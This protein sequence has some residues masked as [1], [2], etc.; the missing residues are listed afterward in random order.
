MTHLSCSVYTKGG[1]LGS[2]TTSHRLVIFEEV[3]MERKTLKGFGTYV[4]SITKQDSTQPEVALC[5]LLVQKTS[6][7]KR[8]MMVATT[9]AYKCMD[10]ATVPLRLWTRSLL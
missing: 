8:R 7:A 10:R 6:M 1:H 5:H 9:H 2:K 3:A 4:P